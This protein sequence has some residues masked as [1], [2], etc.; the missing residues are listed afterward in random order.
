[1]YTKD[2][3]VIN[4]ASC[5]H[6]LAVFIVGDVTITTN[7]IRKG[8]ELGVSFFFLTSNFQP[9]GSCAA[10]AEG[11]YA[12][13][14]RQYALT[15]E[16]ELNLAKFI[17]GNKIKNQ[18]RLLGMKVEDEKIVDIM[19]QIR[20]ASDNQELLGIEGNFAKKFFREYF[21]EIG[22]R[23][24]APR[25]HEDIPNL[26][27][28]IGYTILFNFCDALLRS[29]GFDVYKGFY[30]QLFF[31]RKS[32]VTDIEEPF[33]CVVDKALRRAYSLGM[34]DSKDFEVSKSGEYLLPWKASPKYY[35]IF[36]DAIMD[37]KSEIHEYVGMFYRHV[38]YP[39][40]NRLSDFNINKDYK[41]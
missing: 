25:T 19:L 39:E 40:G 27:L 17:V 2:G 5:H 41:K 9:Y 14:V 21:H 35:R 8:N 24:R 22:W 23:R 36:S 37:R 6:A 31:A 38:M 13:R 30:H 11:N 4:K 15:A 7:V 34:I 1:V 28:D 12:V 3:K 18:A 29:Y 26:L 32:L 33:R 10:Y 16:N 20:F